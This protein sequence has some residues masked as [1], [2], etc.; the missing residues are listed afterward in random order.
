MQTCMV[1]KKEKKM[2]GALG[3]LLK[4]PWGSQMEI[5]GQRKEEERHWQQTKRSVQVKGAG[6]PQHFCFCLFCLFVFHNHPWRLALYKRNGKLLGFV[7]S[8][9]TTI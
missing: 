6:H 4:S 5:Q 8:I 3:I 2:R 1:T 7:Y 9:S